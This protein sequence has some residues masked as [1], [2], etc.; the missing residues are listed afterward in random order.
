VKCGTNGFSANGTAG[1]TGTSF[2]V[3]GTGGGSYNI[4]ITYGIVTG[5][6]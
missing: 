2:W 4:Y 5:V 1:V 3:Q 6:S